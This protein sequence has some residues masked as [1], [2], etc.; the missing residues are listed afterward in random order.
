[1]VT[2]YTPTFGNLVQRALVELRQEPGVSVQQYAEDTLAAIMQRQFNIFFD[3]YWWPAYLTNGEV[4][5]LNGVD[6]RVTT[7]LQDKIKRPEDV[8]YI[9]Y[10][11]YP[12]P[13]NAAPPMMNP[14]SGHFAKYY[15]TVADDKI[16][17]ILPVTT[18]GTISVTYRTKP[19]EFL[20]NDIVKLDGDLLVCATC[21]N[22]LAD[23]E[24]APN[25]LKKF[26]DATAK[27]EAQLREALNRG[28]IPFGA[29]VPS[30]FDG[31]MG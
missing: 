20:P 18:T 3:H 8:R 27:R 13:L 23:D 26:Q 30:P 16:F 22:Y 4:M 10:S 9:W 19:K 5:T 12:I 24:D 15:D 11:N 25:A 28:P 7:N 6:G 2:A 14:N 1:M 21:F 17:R 31:W 29:A